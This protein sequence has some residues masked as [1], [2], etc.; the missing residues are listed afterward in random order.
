MCVD[1]EKSSDE[2]CG[3]CGITGVDVKLK[4]CACNLV[5]YC[6]IKCQKDHRPKHKKLCKKR[7]AEMHDKLGLLIDIMHDK[8]LFTQPDRSYMGECPICCL[9]LSVDENKSV[10]MGCCGKIIC[11]GCEYAIKQRKNEEELDHSCPL[12]QEPMPK[13]QKE[14]DKNHI[15]RIQET[16]D[17]VAMAHIGK[18]HQ[19]KGDY[20]RA[21]QYYTKAAELGGVSAHASLG[22]MYYFG[23]GVEKD[24]KRAV[25]HCEQAAIGGHPAARGILAAHETE[26]GRID[27]AAKHFII[28]ANLGFDMSLKAIKEFFVQGVV[29]KEEYAAALRGYQ[30]AVDA[31][32]SAE[33]E[34]AAR[35]IGLN[36]RSHTR[37]D[38]N[39]G[40]LFEQP[41][42]SH[43][44]ECPICCLPLSLDMNKS[45]FMSCCSK[46]ICDGCYHA[47]KNREIEQGL[48][49]RCAFCRV[50]MPNSR[51]ESIRNMMER[52]KKN[53]PVAMTQMGGRL[54]NEGDYG[55]A[56]EYYTKAA[57]LGD[58]NAHYWLGDLYHNGKNGVEEDAK[59]SIHHFQQAAIGGHTLARV[60]LARY[61]MKN[62]RFDRAVSHFVIA[63]NLGCDTSLGVIKMLVKEGIVSKDEHA[64]ALC[65]YQAAVDATKSAQREKAEE[66]TKNGEEN[67]IYF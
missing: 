35:N 63:A 64:A 15:K 3:S 58:V 67:Y 21:L 26:N 45:T 37:K 30:A 31:T 57:E 49:H 50:R 17:P 24:V 4:K 32:K 29:S 8:Q 40:D 28:S 36:I 52:V 23:E 25:Y 1:D 7:L 20:D 56:F 16:N 48:K 22:G 44:G 51:D 34:E 10:M 53:D 33:R 39:D 65:G 9:P 55:K 13:S 2:V 41:D 47:N 12:C 18:K 38:L 60:Y 19:Q 6:S 14:S 54:T 61:E 42:S 66:A 62:Y 59:K 5:K 43:M 27:R 11:N 46:M